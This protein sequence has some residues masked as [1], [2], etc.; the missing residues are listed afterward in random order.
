MKKLSIQILICSVLILGAKPVWAYP[1]IEMNSC[2][3]NGLTAVAQKGLK[4]SY[5]DVKNYCHCALTKMIDQGQDIN[6]SLSYCNN[7]FIYK[8]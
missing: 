7:R 8:R 1:Q 3:A 4:A 6:G 2:L 5:L